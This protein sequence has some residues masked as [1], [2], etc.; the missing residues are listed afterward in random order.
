MPEVPA[1]DGEAWDAETRRGRPW[2]APGASSGSAAAADRYRDAY[3]LAMRDYALQA[4]G[5]M[6]HASR[7]RAYEPVAQ[8]TE[9]QPGSTSGP[10]ES[11]V[12]SPA[13]AGALKPRGGRREVPDFEALAKLK[14]TEFY[15][16]EEDGYGR[17]WPR[18]PR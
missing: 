18:Q 14:T 8:P 11:S 9:Q 15:G 3:D 10:E 6:S 4:Q 5:S 12:S 1:I 13:I 16:T 7:S 2:G 17:R